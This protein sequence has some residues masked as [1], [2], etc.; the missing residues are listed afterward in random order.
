MVG[1]RYTLRGD[2]SSDVAQVGFGCSRRHYLRVG[3]GCL[4]GNEVPAEE[5][6]LAAGRQY[7]DHCA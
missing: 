3:N 4:V 1:R 6:E 2:I 5:V 7:V